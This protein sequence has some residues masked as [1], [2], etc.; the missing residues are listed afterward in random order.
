[1]KP[2][3]HSLNHVV[4]DTMTAIDVTP[5]ISVQ[6]NATTWRNF[7]ATVMSSLKRLTDAEVNAPRARFRFAVHLQVRNAIQL[8]SE[9]DACRPHRGEIPKSGPSGVHERCR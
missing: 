6:M 3:S 5:T 2:R 4:C 7:R 1:M 8:I 9:V